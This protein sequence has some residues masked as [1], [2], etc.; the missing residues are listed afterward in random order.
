MTQH[1]T[2][3]PSPA[4]HTR[5]PAFAPVPLRYRADGWTPG[6]QADFLGALAETQ[7]VAA[8]AR[9]VG[10]TRESAYRLRDR[11][12]AGSFAAAWDAVLGL[13]LRPRKVT[14]S[15]NFHRAFYG[16]LKPIMRGGKH[17]AT[18]HSS[19]NDAAL[20]LY[21]RDMLIRRLARRKAERSQ[22]K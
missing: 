21:R 19:S 3:R 8:A 7:S 5:V 18:L 13:R 20:Q 14:P 10:M 1:R 11:Q 4:I 22:V 6:R 12:G 17:V 16:T 2:T 15:P 9:H